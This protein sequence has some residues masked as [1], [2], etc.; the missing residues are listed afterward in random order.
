MVVLGGTEQAEPFR[1]VEERYGSTLLIFAS[2]FSATRSYNNRIASKSV[3]LKSD[4]NFL[5]WSLEKR[6]RV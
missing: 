5:E 2:V 6:G 1:G 3:M 4:E